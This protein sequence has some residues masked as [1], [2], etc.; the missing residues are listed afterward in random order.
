MSALFLRPTDPLRPPE[1]PLMGRG[2]VFAIIAHAALVAALSAGVNWRTKAPPVFEA[3]L[4]SA[5]PQAAAPKEVIPPAPEPEP[6][7]FK[8]PEPKPVQKP[9]EETAQAER[10]AEIAIAR[11]QKKKRA[12]EL[13]SERKKREALLAKEKLE[14]ELKDEKLKDEKRKED[15]LKQAKLDKDKKDKQ[16][17]LEKEADAKLDAQRQENLRRIQ[18][19]AG[20]NGAPNATGTALKSSGP[21]ATYGGRIKA[22]IRPNIIF[23]DTPSGNPVAEVEV[24][25]APDGTII[26]RKLVKPSGDTEW[27]KAVLR[28]VDK[29]ET[30]PRDVDGRVPPVLV[31]SF[32]PLE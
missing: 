24:R 8:K 16:L 32:Q 6:E 21:S 11:E 5:V 19:M 13:E 20:A 18:G 17:K 29:T 4:W 23:T 31:I 3:E 30:L 25:V 15:K 22:R 1:T 26:S 28:A 9:V 27:D 12:A 10:D 2:L 14:Q 7:V